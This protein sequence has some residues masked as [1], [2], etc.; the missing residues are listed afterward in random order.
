MYVVKNWMY[1]L[2]KGENTTLFRTEAN[3]NFIQ[4]SI[5]MCLERAFDILKVRL[6]LIMKQSTISLKSMHD[7]ISI[8]IILHNLCI[9]NNKII[10]NE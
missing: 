9:L 7:I 5:M 6:M 4:F 10:R 3:H 1:C 8:C 2:F